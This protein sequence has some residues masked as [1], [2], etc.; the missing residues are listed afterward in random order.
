MPRTLHKYRVC[1]ATENTYAYVWDDHVPTV[2]P[3]NAEH[4]IVP[5]LTTITDTLS[6][7][8]MYITAKSFEGSKGFYMME[9]RRFN[10]LENESI[11]TDDYEFTMPVVIY[12]LTLQAR[13]EHVGDEFDIILSPDT[14]IGGVT[15][16]ANIGDTIIHVSPTVTQY[17]QVGF[18]LSLTD[19][20]QYQNLG[21]VIAIDANAGT[22]TM[23]DPCIMNFA[24]G[25]YVLLNIYMTKSLQILSIDRYSIGYGT[26]GGKALPAGTK[27]RMVYKNNGGN[28]KM[29]SYHFEYTY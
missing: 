3:N 26:M 4:T 2:C 19:G 25:S 14:P 29:I 18:H 17:A 10:V 1:C 28:F 23:K 21:V 13:L 16:P 22:V 9:G 12:G 20:V 11:K 5:E 8:A 6:E 7:S 27:I 15:M 24:P